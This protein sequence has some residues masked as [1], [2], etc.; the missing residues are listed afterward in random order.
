MSIAFLLLDLIIYNLTTYRTYFIL[1]AI[2]F[3][4]KKNLIYLILSASF[5]DLLLLHTFPLNT[6]LFLILYY[7]KTKI[8]TK[9][10][11]ITNYIIITIL[12][13]TIFLSLSYLINNY[14]NI[15]IIYFIKYYFLNL[16]LFAIVATICYISKLKSIKLNRWFYGR[17]YWSSKK[18][19]QK[20]TI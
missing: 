18:T 16:I 20:Q 14:L 4:T 6:G 9:K 17:K 7:L 15:Q 1:V 11:T 13:Y 5:I 19:N 2:P 12:N 10:Q 8:Y 3:T